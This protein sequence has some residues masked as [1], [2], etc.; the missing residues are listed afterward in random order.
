M[1]K[2]KGII[3][4]ASA[5]T[6]IGGMAAQTV[7]V[8]ANTIQ[9]GTTPVTYDNRQVLPDGNGQYGMIIPTAIT[10]TDD[11]Q[12][13]DA[14]IEIT[15]IN[16]Y[17]LDKD[18]TELDVTAKVSSK[19][20]YELK[21][22]NKSVAYEIQMDNNADK[23]EANDAEQEVTKRFGVGKA[24]L[25]KKEGGTARLGGKATVKGQYKDTLTYTFTENVNTLK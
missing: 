21:D 18:W 3:A 22:G 10:F 19:N 20:S 6:V 4:L 12:E 16:G 13:A 15:G 14:A 24:D 25:V 7:P 5:A 8:F 11:K 17:D 23:F 1:F 2:K 9:T